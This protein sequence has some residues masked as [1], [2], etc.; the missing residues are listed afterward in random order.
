MVDLPN[1]LSIVKS[2]TLLTENDSFCLYNFNENRTDFDTD[3][4]KKRLEGHV[5]D[6]TEAATYLGRLEPYKGKVMLD[7]IGDF[8]L[9]LD[10]L[11]NSIQIH[12][13]KIVR[14]LDI[15]QSTKSEWNIKSKVK[16]HKGKKV[17]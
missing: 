11:K 9:K 4:N 1:V 17:Y 7:A 8:D 2:H 16:A 12:Y 6:D 10:G 13:K 5:S 14:D 3:Q 15:K